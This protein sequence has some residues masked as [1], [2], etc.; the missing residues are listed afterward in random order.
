MILHI[1]L[2]LYCDIL[3]KYLNLKFSFSKKLLTFFDFPIKHQCLINLKNGTSICPINEDKAWSKVIKMR[4]KKLNLK[5]ILFFENFSYNQPEQKKSN[6]PD[7]LLKKIKT[8]PAKETKFL[9]ENQ[10]T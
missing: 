1:I 6:S 2:N 4:Q 10:I 5:Q 8:L 3:I 9:S 7:F